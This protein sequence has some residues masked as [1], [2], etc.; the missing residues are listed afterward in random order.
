MRNPTTLDAYLNCLTTLTAIDGR[1]P[2]T[3][4]NVIVVEDRI[5]CLSNLLSKAI[6]QWGLL[7]RGEDG[8]EKDNVFLPEIEDIAERGFKNFGAYPKEKSSAIYVLRHKADEKKLRDERIINA[9]KVLAA[10][11]RA[12]EI[13]EEARIDARQE[14]Q[15][16]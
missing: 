9:E 14:R 1:L 11:D 5:R 16:S 13:R 8:G 12:N 7:A 6:I 15:S 2:F 4:Q 3:P 10:R